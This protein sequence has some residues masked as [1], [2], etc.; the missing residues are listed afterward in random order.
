MKYFILAALVLLLGPS[1][2]AA[3]EEEGL[4]EVVTAT[5]TPKAAEDE[6]DQA[7]IQE[8]DEDLV[9]FVMDYIRRDTQLKGG[10]LI[11]DKTSKKILKLNMVSVEQ[12]VKDGPGGTKTVESVFQDAAAQKF[13]V[14]FS[15]Q[16]GSWGG[17][18]ISRI[19][20]K[21]TP[22]PEKPKKP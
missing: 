8:S 11:E 16:N 5:D 15:L 1:A 22:A 3:Y 9:D 17:L 12:T 21:K 18:D 13:S 14:T 6:D 2:K 4:S 20:V 10:F 19:E 7:V